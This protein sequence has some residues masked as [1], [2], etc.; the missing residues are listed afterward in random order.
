[1]FDPTTPEATVGNFENLVL[2]ST[3]YK[4][5][6]NRVMH[7]VIRRFRTVGTIHEMATGYFRAIYMEKKH[8]GDFRTETGAIASIIAHNEQA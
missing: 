5:C 2:P 6:G 4:I 8:V 3:N 7:R 1:M